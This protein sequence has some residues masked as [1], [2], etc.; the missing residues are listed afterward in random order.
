MSV[1]R[2]TF[3]HHL[4][5]ICIGVLFFLALDIAILKYRDW[6]NANKK[7]NNIYFSFKTFNTSNY[8]GLMRVSAAKALNS[9]TEIRLGYKYPD[10]CR[11][12]STHK[13]KRKIPVQL[14]LSGSDNSW[15]R[16]GFIRVG[17]E[18]EAEK[19]CLA[20]YESKYVISSSPELRNILANYKKKPSFVAIAR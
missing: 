17:P 15:L 7:P 2:V 4:V 16:P 14:V 20:S 1:N 13:D 12:L 6:D 8:I 19:V 5:G 18:R 9:N 10:V 11:V 3:K